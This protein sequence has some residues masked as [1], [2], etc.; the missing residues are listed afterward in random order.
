MLQPPT[1]SGFHIPKPS[2]STVLMTLGAM[3]E[4][5]VSIV[6]GPACGLVLSL[7]FGHTV[8][9]VGATFLALSV[10]HPLFYL[11][12]INGCVSLHQAQH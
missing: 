10:F 9:H 6:W 4:C 7:S 11:P 5:C 8:T 3:S 2:V 12:I 1:P